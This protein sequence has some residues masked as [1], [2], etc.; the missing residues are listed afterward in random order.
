MLFSPANSFNDYKTNAA[1]SSTAPGQQLTANATPNTEG[2]WTLI[3]LSG[4]NIDI[5]WLSISIIDGFTAATYKSLWL[6]IGVDNAGGTSYTAIIN[7]LLVSSASG[8]TTAGGGLSFCFPIFIKSGSTVAARIQANVASATCRIVM[9]AFGRP[10]APHL[11][12][13]GTFAETIG[14]GTAPAATAFTPGNS[15]ANGS[16]VSLGTTT[17]DLFWFQLGVQCTNTTIT[18]LAYN[19][20]LAYGDGTNFVMLIEDMRVVTTTSESIGHWCNTGA[21]MRCQT[22]VPAGSTLYVRGSCSGTAVT[23]WQA[24]C[25][26]V[27]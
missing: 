24:A 9:E 23:G 14:L 21:M 7:N 20:D 15:G 13:F 18:A 3:S 27:G 5:Y 6:D 10:N 17:N 12:P 2:A 4:S 11:V 16:W 26:G 25:I 22:P 19:F 1:T 8:S